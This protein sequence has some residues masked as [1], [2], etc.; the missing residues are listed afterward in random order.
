MSR[1]SLVA[2]ARTQLGY[3]E[4]P[5]N[6]TKYGRQFGLDGVFWCMQF[7]WACFHNSGNRGLVPKTAS[8]R[9]LFAAAKRADRGLTLLP[10]TATPMPGDLVEFDMGGPKPVNH[11]GI[12][13]RVLPGGRFV[14]IEGNTGGRGPDGER[15]GGMV[16]RKNRDR[17]HVVSFV[18]PRF[19][20]VKSRAVSSAVS[21][22]VSGPPRFP[23]TI[24]KAGSKGRVVKQI[25]ARLNVIGKGR[26][27]VLGGARLAVDGDFGPKT[28]KVV[29]AF[30]RRCG[31]EVDG[32]VGPNTWK[33]LFG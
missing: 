15:N 21:S 20:P 18:R 2:H 26:H 9:A 3:V 29:K 12:V 24:I 31:L 17:R 5:V 11:I 1:E 33:R 22:A 8:T 25:Q 23:G 13:E 4:R 6:R 28:D 16:A 32:E 30:Q 19:A 14:S 10:K 27:A 7:V